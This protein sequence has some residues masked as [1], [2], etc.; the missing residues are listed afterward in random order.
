MSTNSIP[1]ARRYLLNEPVLAHMATVGP[2]G[3]PQNN[4]VWFLWEDGR[5]V[6]SIGPEGQKARNLERNP[7]VALSMA[8]REKPEVYLE[9]RGQV[10]DRRTVDSSDPLLVAL[11][12][13]YTGAD[14]Y[15]G[16]PDDHTLVFIEPTRYTTMG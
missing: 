5:V 9:L 3:E 14:S 13:K 8:D 7:R 11:V 15:E 16:M 2:N 12:R 4:P 6:I 10:V 1:E